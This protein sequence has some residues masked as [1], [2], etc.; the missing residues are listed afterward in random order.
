M[1]E[2]RARRSQPTRKRGGR[3]RN[4]GNLAANVLA[5]LAALAI[6]WI[7]SVASAAVADR[8]PTPAPVKYFIVS[9][10]GNGP[11]SLFEIA[12]R[13]LGDGSRFMQIFRLNKGRLQ[14]NG[15]RMENPRI[16]EPGWV[17]QLPPGASGPGVHFGPLPRPKPSASAAPPSQPPSRPGGASSSSPVDLFVTILAFVIAGALAVVGARLVWR[18]RMGRRRR[19]AERGREHRYDRVGHPR[20]SAKAP[21]I[22]ADVTNPADWSRSSSISAPADWPADH[23][24][25]PQQAVDY[26][27]WPADHPSRPQQAVDYRRQP[28]PGPADPG[29]WAGPGQLVPATPAGFGDAPLNRP[30]PAPL[31]RHSRTS[32]PSFAPAY[33][34]AAEARAE[35]LE[36]TDALRVASLLL[37]EAEAE[38]VRIRAEATAF[39][40]RATTQAVSVREAAEREAEKLRASLHALSAELNEVAAFVTRKLEVPAESWAST[41][42]DAAGP[43]SWSQAMPATPARTAAADRL[44]AVPPVSEPKARTA[45]KPDDAPSRERRTRRHTSPGSAPKTSP[46]AKPGQRPRQL[47][48]ARIV[49]AAFIG[50]SFLSVATGTAEIFL[51]GFP[52]FAFRSAGTGSTPSN[53]R[54]ED[55]G[56]GQP[57][58]PGARHHTAPRH[59]QDH[60]QRSAR[61][62]AGGSTH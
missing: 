21:S 24:S 50:L 28:Y 2:A 11:A 25:R 58:A 18:P 1:T 47:R 19:A 35:D 26:R 33:G 51:H 17:L 20:T 49:V 27:D 22:P 8:T 61:R 14:P 56:P 43:E 6:V 9:A 52:F 12:A 5:A 42:A 37:A 46:A 16:I 40:E 15:G 39:R 34:R 32:P 30:G 36:P 44:R 4:A 41:Q 31:P 23:P 38:A 13:T 54:Q 29:G 3:P 45:T 57:D 60:Q 48:A 53:G 55:Q 62:H 59:H 10:R 7:G